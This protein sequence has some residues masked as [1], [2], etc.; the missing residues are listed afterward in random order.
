[1]PADEEKQAANEIPTAKGAAVVDAA[2]SRPTL[3]A[4]DGGKQAW[5]FLAGAAVIEIVAWGFPYCYGVFRE[6]FF[7]HGPFQ[8][9][10]YVSVAGVAA[11]VGSRPA[12]SHEAAHVENRVCSKYLSHS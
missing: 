1:M 8:G 10:E 7:N 4:Q 12:E 9:I 11:N 2:S 6:Y 5:L 3:P